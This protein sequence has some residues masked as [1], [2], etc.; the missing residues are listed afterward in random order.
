MSRFAHYLHNKDGSSN[1]NSLYMSECN[2]QKVFIYSSAHLRDINILKNR[3]FELFP[4]YG[5]E[6]NEQGSL[7][8]QNL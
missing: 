5:N 2:D 6:D 4:F 3:M 8:N 7:E 1:D